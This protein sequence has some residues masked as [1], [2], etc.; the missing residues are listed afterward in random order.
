VHIHACLCE[1]RRRHLT[2]RL[3]SLALSHGAHL[4]DTKPVYASP[5]GIRMFIMF[6][7]H[8]HTYIFVGECHCSGKDTERH[9]HTHAR[10]AVWAYVC[11]LYKW[12]EILR[13][14]HVGPLA[15]KQ[16]HTHHTQ[17]P[18][19]RTLVREALVQNCIR[20]CQHTHTYIHFNLWPTNDPTVGKHN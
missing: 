19:P 17:T 14:R 10:P 4:L 15:S 12:N 1:D 9:T 5:V 20:R 18:A 8:T 2:L 6:I 13:I 7:T 3:L 11:A 16:S